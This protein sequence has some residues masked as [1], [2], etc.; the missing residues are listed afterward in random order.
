MEYIKLMRMKHYIKNMLIFLPLFFSKNILD[1]K[2]LINTIIGFIVFSILTSIVY[3][4][5]DILDVEQDKKHPQKSNRPIASGKISIKKAYIFLSILALVDIL[6]AIFALKLSILGSIFA[7]GYLVMNLCY[8]TKL[9]RVPILDVTIISLGFLIRLLFGSAVTGI[10]VSNLLYLTV[11]AVS[12]YLG[13][14]KRRNELIKI[15]DS[16]REVLKRIYKELSR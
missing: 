8:S 10:E 6:I 3:I 11:L 5:N 7:L 2:L 12:F 15:E 9:K 14:G 1:I 13:L 4:F 16:A